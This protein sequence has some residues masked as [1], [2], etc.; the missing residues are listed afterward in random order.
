MNFL[1]LEGLMMNE[2]FRN[3]FKGSILATRAV[4]DCECRFGARVAVDATMPKYAQELGIQKSCKARGS[5]LRGNET[6]NH[7]YSSLYIYVCMCVF[8]C[9]CE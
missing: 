9:V 4:L 5:E 3:K 7:A 1:S 8:V 6:R 2:R